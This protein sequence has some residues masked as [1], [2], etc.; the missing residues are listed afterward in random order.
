MK[1]REERFIKFCE[2]LGKLSVKH[3][4]TIYSCGGV[5]IHDEPLE[6]VIYC[7]D[8]TSGDLDVVNIEEKDADLVGSGKSEPWELK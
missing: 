2:E 7:D 6:E 8:H 4:V 1:S 3:G 5:T